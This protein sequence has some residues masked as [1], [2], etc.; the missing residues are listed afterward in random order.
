MNPH[1]AENVFSER[2]RDNGV[3]TW[4]GKVKTPLESENVALIGENAFIERKRRSQRRKN[5][6]AERNLYSQ[7]R[8]CVYQAK[9]WHQ[10]ALIASKCENVARKG[11][12]RTKTWL[13]KVNA[14][15]ECIRSKNAF[16]PRHVITHFPGNQA[17]YTMAMRQVWDTQFHGFHTVLLPRGATS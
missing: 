5:A 11:V 13:A 17:R 7:R 1:K 3:N 12:Y 15:S 6:S 16:L 8:K 14:F 9:T 4:L 2:K 10:K